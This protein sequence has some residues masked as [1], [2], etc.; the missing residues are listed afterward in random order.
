MKKF[1]IAMLFVVVCLS[2]DVQA[3]FPTTEKNKQPPK[4]KRRPIS[5]RNSI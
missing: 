4:Q 2:V 3:Q 5:R 1:V